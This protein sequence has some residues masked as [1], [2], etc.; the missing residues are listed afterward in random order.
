MPKTTVSVNFNGKDGGLSNLFN[1]LSAAVTKLDK[2]LSSLDSTL[3][4][5]DARLKGMQSSS[6]FLSSLGKVNLGSI[7]GGKGGGSGLGLNIGNVTGNLTSALTSG[8]S[9]AG[10]L[11]SSI[12]SGIVSTVKSAVSNSYQSITGFISY[13]DKAVLMF[14]N[15]IR[16]IAQG[17]QSF[18]IAFSIFVSAPL[19]KLL[20]GV[21]SESVEFDDAL[22][23]IR[24][25]TEASTD[26]IG[27]LGASLTQLS[28]GLPETRQDLAAIAED[29]GAVGIT[30]NNDSGVKQM[31]EL[32]RLTAML[33]SS[34][35]GLSPGDAVEKL[36]KF[37]A[38]YYPDV[39]DF[40]GEAEKLFSVI[41]K[42]EDVTPLDA[43]DILATAQR[44]ASVTKAL[45]I[46]PEKALAL[47]AAVASVNASAERAG[48][49]MATALNTM[50]VKTD[51]VAALFGTTEENVK[52]LMAG[53]PEDFFL[54][55]ASSIAAIE[56]PL[57][58]VRETQAVFGTTGGKA[59]GGLSG[60]IENVAR[61]MAVAND[62]F[63][64]GTYLQFQFDA[65]LES[66]K[67]QLSILRNNLTY[68]GSAIG[69]AFLP[70]ITKFVALAVPAIQ[71]LTDWFKNL[72]ESVKVQI[73]LWAALL[74]VAGPVV[75]FFS[76]MLFMVGLTISGL[77][78]MFG[79]VMMI[80]KG[81][82]GFGGVVLGL[83]NP[84]NL[85]VAGLAGV[86]IYAVFLANDLLMA[87]GIVQ[88]YISKAYQWGY[89]LIASFA[90][91]IRSAASAAYNAVVAV[92]NAFIGLIQAFSPPREGPL[93]GIES[94]GENLMMAYADGIMASASGVSAAVS[95][96]DEQLA[97]ML[98]SLS[99]S[100]V[101][102]FTDAFNGI[103][104]I[105]NTVGQHIGSTAGEINNRIS[106]AASAVANFISNLRS[107]IP[108]DLTEIYEM[109]GGLGPRYEE[110]I[111]LQETYTAGEARLKAIQAALK[112]INS[113][114]ESL[115]ANVVSQ[116][117]LTNDQQ[118][119]M[120]RRI[121]L[122]QAA[123]ETA[124]KQEEDSIQAQQDALK[125]DIDKKQSIIDVLASLIF[126]QENVSAGTGKVDKPDKPK[127]DDGITPIDMVPFDP[128]T[129]GALDNLKDKFEKTGESA[130]TFTEK[131]GKAKTMIEGLVAGLRGDDPKL[132]SAMPEA[133]WQGFEKG[134]SIR[135]SVLEFLAKFDSFVRSLGT[136]KD[137][138]KDGGLKFLL[139]ISDGASGGE[140]N[141]DAIAY[142]G[143]FAGSLY[144]LGYVAGVVGEK[145]KDVF[146]YLFTKR[147][148]GDEPTPFEQL[149]TRITNAYSAF[150][151]GFKEN[152]KDIDWT[153]F[154]QAVADMAGAL[155][156]V[157]SDESVWRAIGQSLGAILTI[158]TDLVIKLARLMHIVALIFGAEDEKR[159]K[160][161]YG[162]LKASTDQTDG[163]WSSA[164]KVYQIFKDIKDI[165]KE[166]STLYDNFMST[167][168]GKTS[169]DPSP[170]TGG[171]GSGG[172]G[173]G[174]SKDHQSS[175]GG[176]YVKGKSAFED[177]KQGFTDGI[178]EGSELISTEITG[179][180]G[181]GEA[182]Q[183]GL[184]LNG[185]ISAGFYLMGLYN[186][187]V[188]DTPVGTAMN[189]AIA[190]VGRWLGVATPEI[191]THGRTF[192]Q[193]ML[194]GTGATF[195]EQVEP[196]KAMNQLPPAVSKWE[197]AN[198]TLIEDKGKT[199]GKDIT[200]GTGYITGTDTG[201]MDLGV[202]AMWIWINTQWQRLVDVG[203]S[204]G[205]GVIEGIK[206]AFSGAGD[207]L[208][209]AISGALDW[210]Y[211]KLPDWFLI[212]IGRKP[213][214]PQNEENSVSNN[215]E[216][217]V[218]NNGTTI[219]KS[220]LSIPH[221][222]V[223]NTQ[224]NI[225]ITVN[226]DSGA[227]G[228]KDNA[229]TL[230]D[231]IYKRLIQDGR[232]MR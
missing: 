15:S 25:T 148:G 86:A 146:D 232:L 39:A 5:V 45:D 2:E 227:I 215:E 96:V 126:P 156:L 11:V 205:S 105:I 161:M 185:R 221:P 211:K 135:D 92:I 167:F 155:G 151:E 160:E 125:D 149:L 195:V 107:G 173:D 131:L 70:Y 145:V 59:L 124:L 123:K 144:I 103:K 18:G 223:V 203:K 209:G 77:S 9:R 213:A 147:E 88:S 212:L 216:N 54:T 42:L 55:I 51:K 122:E 60:S 184:Q 199:I 30:I 28:L 139:G 171:G 165:I 159:F 201:Y 99:P 163:F 56:D 57:E 101:K 21:V 98:E 218:S 22:V 46:A 3:A 74:T 154:G 133:F 26:D 71:M 44:M 106:G 89:N 62:E 138:I 180:V 191:D 111:R 91:G 63:V 192:G 48:T 118:A 65:A 78:S 80:I 183:S 115:I 225:Y 47:A 117:G 94:W 137:V 164:D 81:L 169:Q 90:D 217:S 67:N 75:V 153:S 84:I 226:V 10:S 162:S 190:S 128:N 35:R 37:A 178:T 41:S 202:S 214:E 112:G 188:S 8:L 61:I 76:S 110:L 158:S 200:K 172:F 119:A 108:D 19:G 187:F 64:K 129:G 68:A 52:S 174:S 87:Q 29:W 36:G 53:H 16:Q 50:V 72:G 100:G 143:I 49:Q 83:L 66:T 102:A 197:A 32:V 79:V 20:S 127:K 231:T 176:M 4:R 7:L 150:V 12:F 116:T 113:E 38:I 224:P 207:A 175:T 140:L 166:I 219:N 1:K 189:E 186:E 182:L 85:L 136:I 109:L 177:F 141:W 24:K 69:D 181:L 104:S 208:W 14:G 97:G 120:I 198:K 220:S 152:T 194:D 193:L 157:S 27:K 73:L 130:M 210:V 93:T 229:K 134:K 40:V 204:W 170:Q 82:I 196:D 206:S 179:K 6:G 43:G 17:I 228:T 33:S 132:Y 13:A 230:A 23:K 142:M 95:Y 168:T 58:R 121:K 34:T 222:P 31:T 114:T